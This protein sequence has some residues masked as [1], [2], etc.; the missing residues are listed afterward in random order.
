MPIFELILYI[1][2]A[3]VLSSFFE[4]FIPKVALPLVQIAMGIIAAQLPFFPDVQLDPTLFMVL[5]V[6]PLLY[7][8]S[9]EINKLALFASLKYSASLAVGLV[10]LTMC[11][12]GFALPIFWPLMPLTAAIV[13]GA[14]LGPTDAVAVS[15]LA[16]EV[17]LSRHQHATLQGES[18]FN[19][20]TS[21]V[22]FQFAVLAASSGSFSIVPALQDF[23]VKVF[24]GIL[25][26]ALVGF[27]ANWI[28]ERIRFLGWETTKTRILMELS[29]PFLLYMGSERLGVSG[30]L[31]LVVAGLMARFDRSAVGPNVSRTNIVAGSVWSVLT[32]SLNGA[33]FLL[34]GISLPRAIGASWNDE[35]SSNTMLIAMI[36]TTIALVILLR[37]LWMVV[38][39]H[40]RR[41]GSQGKSSRHFLTLSG[42]KS[43]IVMTLGG[44]KGT[45][46]LAL[47]FT[48]PID[49][50]LRNELIFVASA[51]IL[52]TL[53][54]ANFLLPLF[55]PQ[56]TGN[57]LEEV[58]PIMIE[59]LRRTVEE[60]TASMGS[61]NRQA[62]LTVIHSYTQRI[63]R[64]KQRVGKY[65]AQE[66]LQVRIAAL[67]WEK[68]YLKERL[69]NCKQ[70]LQALL[71]SQALQS[72]QSSQLS[73]SAQDDRHSTLR[74][75][76]LQ[77]EACERLLDQLMHSLRHI[78][79]DH[80]LGSFFW[81]IKGRA[82]AL[83]RKTLLLTRRISNKIRRDA[84]MLREDLVFSHM[85]RIQIDAMEYVIE[86]LYLETYHDTYNTE[87]CTSLMFEYRKVEG[88]LRARPSMAMGARLTE[89]VE[90][91]KRVS[92][93][94]ELRIIHE[95]YEAGE[96]TRVQ[97]RQLRN[98]VYVMNVDADSDL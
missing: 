48:L 70:T 92:Y 69:Q 91:V 18:L 27:V 87:H 96:I 98:N 62:L 49:F 31:A 38:M 64:L 72:S 11:V 37:F 58:A 68:E 59:I 40:M 75:A 82:R 25:I 84:P 6:A 41:R 21:I 5:I 20:A 35:Y 86:R 43:A 50:P 8:E 10:F 77:V 15:A 34:L 55:A 80:H 74:D 95:M 89:C 39:V 45:L 24:G 32:F 30:M 57:E 79:T 53:I 16:H 61:G 81:H 88:L 29:I 60:L 51:A 52:V 56:K 65:D 90:E 33:V 9:R 66:D 93:A 76:R 7:F 54:M 36:A 4:R 3:V 83:Q 13:L 85:R 73:Q 67:E 47:M 71:A 26:G 1:M 17:S 2:A 14:A 44:A 19:D 97:E 94:T 46:T 42:W 78:R 12:V 23:T 63:E 22:G 28:F